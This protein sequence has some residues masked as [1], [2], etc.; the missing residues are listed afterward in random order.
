MRIRI[1][2]ISILLIVVF[3]GVSCI[4][5][6]VFVGSSTISNV[7]ASPEIPKATD[8]VVISAK[9]TDLKGVLSAK[10]YFKSI[11][12]T[13]F[14]NVVMT[15][16][17]NHIFSGEI[18]EYPLDTVVQYYIEVVNIDNLT[19]KFPPTAPA[20]LAL[21]TVG[22][23]TSSKIFVNEVFP[24]GTK[25]ATDP[26]WVEFYNDYDVD[27][28]I[29]GYYFYDNGILAANGTKPKRVIENGVII[30]AKGFLV[31]K[32][33]TYASQY[34][35]EFGLS[36]GGDGIYLENKE[37]ILVAKLDFSTITTTGKKSYGRKPD[38]SSTLVLFTTA[39]RGSSNNNAN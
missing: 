10:L 32:A 4:N 34:A 22:V 38:G 2:Q 13:S 12:S 39:T 18:S 3:L 27:V 5:D 36:T 16:G 19:T 25:D 1:F 6:T 17:E 7:S 24:D 31:I 35:V 33:E 9:I 14:T 8:S 26:D 20:S 23:N 15:E 29:S 11:G 30:P 28:D 37:G 21:Y